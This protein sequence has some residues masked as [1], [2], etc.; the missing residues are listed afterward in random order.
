M[1]LAK[2]VS[3]EQPLLHGDTIC[4][5]NDPTPKARQPMPVLS[6][7][8]TEED[9]VS[10]ARRKAHADDA[11]PDDPTTTMPR[12]PSQ[13]FVDW[14]YFIEKVGRITA[15]C[16]IIAP[17]IVV[18]MT[19]AGPNVIIPLV[20]SLA[21]YVETQAEISKSLVTISRD[22]VSATASS[23]EQNKKI[24]ARIDHLAARLDANTEVQKANAEAMKRLWQKPPGDAQ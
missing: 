12:L 4:G 8:S 6:L 22:S 2:T 23:L 3:M 10:P 11:G 5:A 7:V 21:K 16:F 14:A 18:A 17:T 13:K 19:W 9:A 20:S 15:F 24:E 1:T